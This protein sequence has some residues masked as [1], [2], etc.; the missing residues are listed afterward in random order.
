MCVNIVWSVRSLSMYMYRHITTQRS[1]LQALVSKTTRFYKRPAYK[2]SAQLCMMLGNEMRHCVC[3]NRVA[4]V[5]LC[6]VR[7]MALSGH[8]L[9]SY[10]RERACVTQTTHEGDASCIAW[11]SKDI[12][13][14]AVMKDPPVAAW[15]LRYKP[16]DSDCY[17]EL[18]MAA[19][20][21]FLSLRLQWHHTCL[22]ML[23]A[24]DQLFF[25][26]RYWQH[27]ANNPVQANKPC[28]GV[29]ALRKCLSPKCWPKTL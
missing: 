18:Q 16:G 25:H 9:G 7:N 20:S 8:V 4:M 2:W 12:F 29:C 10:W 14:N 28:F 22:P 23:V 26:A 27:I 21:T 3:Q 24:R 5:L 6:W 1:L 17:L 11:W 13:Q 19:R 15:S